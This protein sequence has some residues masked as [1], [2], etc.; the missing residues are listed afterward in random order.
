MNIPAHPAASKTERL[1]NA[2]ATAA[3]RVGVWL[4]RG[5]TAWLALLALQMVQG[6]G[7]WWMREMSG[8]DTSYY[9][10]SV[11]R[12]MREGDLTQLIQGPFYKLWL[13]LAVVVAG[14]DPFWAVHLHRFGIYLL[15][16]ALLLWLFRR[17]LPG[18]PLLAWGAAAAW[19]LNPA[20]L[21]SL[22]ELHLFSM[23]LLLGALGIFS[24]G[25]RWGRPAGCGLL[26]LLAVFVRNEYAVFAA[27]GLAVC[28][29][30]DRGR[31]AW[32][33]CAGALALTGLAAV[34]MVLAVTGG[35]V[36]KWTAGGQRKRDHQFGQ[37]FAFYYAQTHPEWGKN[38][39]LHYREV[40]QAVFGAEHVGLGEALRANP[41]A[42]ARFATHNVSQMHLGLQLLWLGNATRR[43]D[44]AG[45]VAHHPNFWPWVGLGLLLPLMALGLARLP[46]LDPRDARWAVW[47]FL[48]AGPL[49]L[50]TTMI[51]RATPIY[52]LPLG[53]LGFFLA[54]L[55][56]E[57]ITPLRSRLGVLARAGAAA[58]VAVA[59]LRPALIM[60]PDHQ[61][62]A[63][64][65][66]EF[67][68]RAAE[69]E[70]TGFRLGVR[71]FGGDTFRYLGFAEG[72][73]LVAPLPPEAQWEDEAAWRRHLQETEATWFF[74]DDWLNQGALGR[75]LPEHARWGWET[76]ARGR[77]V[78][79]DWVLLR[80][81]A[82]VK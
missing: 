44:F 76:V 70:R 74:A 13:A 69:P 62:L 56:L 41:G 59:F 73:R 9:Y 67:R 2:M 3:R 61:V 5:S 55:G 82:E 81:T 38:P 53:P 18:R 40:N 58:T 80:R 26:L 68:T 8:G 37:G 48:A 79:T 29:G 27:V 49:A 1:S 11:L 35:D 30:V 52:M 15:Q 20:S 39:F 78:R 17:W 32:A 12:L 43:V 6:F 54:A 10:R 63:T 45:T 36:A 34:L 64:L 19:I 47:V 7:Y 60:P 46:G 14:G 4:I 24:L 42:V 25:G 57:S 72:E 75:V 66:R 22:Y 50:L 23:V 16:G 21:H 31:A 28:L 51:Q 65:V 77:G 33:R 71:A